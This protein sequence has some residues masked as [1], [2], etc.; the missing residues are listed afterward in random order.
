M[1]EVSLVAES[2]KTSAEDPQVDC[3]EEAVRAEK[4]LSED[5]KE[6]SVGS[7]RGG[8]DADEVMYDIDIDSTEENAQCS[9]TDVEK[10]NEGSQSECILAPACSG[11]NA[12]HMSGS[13]DSGGHETNHHAETPEAPEERGE[14]HTE[15]QVIFA[16]TLDN[17][18][19]QAHLYCSGGG[20]FST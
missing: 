1:S 3:E 9:D 7:G 15:T 4:S 2:V 16:F 17:Q 5:V 18:P 12:A 14:S 13:A 6:G 10:V 11:S 8:D 20:L 19:L